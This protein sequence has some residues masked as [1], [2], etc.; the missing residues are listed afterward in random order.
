MMIAGCATPAAPIP[1]ARHAANVAAAERAGYK[2]VTK[3]D[4]TQFCPTAPTT[5]THMAPVCM[6]ER[7]F[8]SLL[9]ASRSAIPDAHVTSTPPGPA[10]GH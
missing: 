6:T 7:E 9:G 1:E 3:G 4:R 5:G 10:S 8:E 2:V